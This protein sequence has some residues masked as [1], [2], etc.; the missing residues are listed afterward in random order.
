MKF[1]LIFHLNIFFSSISEKQRKEVINKC[2]WPLLMLV[3]NQKI[4]ISIELTG[5]TLEIINKLDKKF[6]KKLKK[7]IKEGFVTLIGSGYAQII[8]PLIQKNINQDNLKV[9][10][11]I[12]KK[13]LD[14]NPKI[15]LVNEQ[16]FSKGLIKIY[17]DAGFEKIIIE[18]N[19]FFSI[20]KNFNDKLRYNPQYL[21][22]DYNNLIEVIWNDSTMFQ[23]FQ[24][25]IHDEFS[26]NKYLSFIKNY[27]KNQKG[28][29][30]L[31]GNDVEIFNFRPGRH[32]EEKK[33]INNEWKKIENFLLKISKRYEIININQIFNKKKK[34]LKSSNFENS[35]YV[36]KQKKYNITRWA[37]TGRN[38][39]YINS[40][41]HKKFQNTNL[42]KKSIKKKLFLLS[43]DFRT[44]ITQ[45]R[46]NFFKKY[47]NKDKLYPSK[48]KLTKFKLKNF[49]S[50]SFEYENKN[51]KIILDITK[52]LTIDKLVD[53]KDNNF[54]Y[55][56]ILKQGEFSDV[57]YLVDFFSSHLV[58]E[59]KKYGKITNLHD[60]LSG[61]FE[62][63]NYI[64]LNNRIK[65]FEYNIE[66]SIKVYKKKKTIELRCDVKTNLFNDIKILRPFHFTLS[67][68]AKKDSLNI[69]IANG[70]QI[71][72]YK[73][74]EK[75]NFSQSTQVNNFISATTLS[76]MTNN[77]IELKY[78]NKFLKFTDLLED[79]KL[80]PM[81][82]YVNIDKKKLLRLIFTVKENDE[83]S[84]INELKKLSSAVKIDF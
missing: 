4:P 67:P 40:F 31:Y 83:T 35:I 60:Q 3:S 65:A 73:I 5:L 22:D 44:H 71:E 50:D 9:G 53:K 38:D 66:K 16:A 29:L 52:G 28:Y 18:S 27:I 13:L 33:I 23:Q 34:I 6:I 11:K 10:K 78:N 61:Y 47:L 80:Y 59:S 82:D 8:G 46:W 77:S 26:E 21:S 14:D 74:N 32:K 36:K 39:T 57:N 70:G 17:K 84:K 62:D 7:L 37:V 56:N 49:D 25:F 42:Q 24:R 55:I 2:Y 30:S 69:L 63:D 15:A 58:I 19:N 54:S 64:Y 68:P 79:T 48:K 51:F 1:Y 41:L 76:G 72:N 43:S 20:N 12:Y 75:D 45:K 81:I